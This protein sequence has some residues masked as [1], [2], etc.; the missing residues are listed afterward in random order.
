MANLARRENILDGLFDF[1][2]DFDGLF[3]LLLAHSS[4]GTQNPVALFATVPAIEAR[5]DVK[6]SQYHLRVSLPCV[7]PSEVQINLQGKDLTISGEH[8]SEQEK[9]ESN[10]M[11]KEFSYE[12]F[13]RTV[14]LPEIA[15]KEKISADFNNGVLEITAPLISSALPKRIEIQS[16]QKAKGAT[17]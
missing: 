6:D 8:N 13:E 17:A 3:N 7:D 16:L 11:R 4:Q 1:R 14:T 15:D 12:H 5:V 9:K 10:Y 2:R